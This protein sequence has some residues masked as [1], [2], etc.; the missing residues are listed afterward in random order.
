MSSLYSKVTESSGKRRRFV[1]RENR[2]C[3]MFSVT[4]KLNA[5]VPTLVF[6]RL[7]KVNLTTSTSSWLE[8]RRSQ[9][10]PRSRHR[11]NALCRGYLPQHDT[12]PGSVGSLGDKE[13]GCVLLTLILKEPVRKRTFPP[14]RSLS[15]A[16]LQIFDVCYILMSFLLIQSKV[17]VV[18]WG[19][20]SDGQMKLSEACIEK[21]F[22]HRPLWWH[23]VA[24]NMK[25][26]WICLM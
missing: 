19:L 22:Q 14:F 17:F 1:T 24:K 5:H 11:W 12:C 25:R 4:H 26:S 16:S 21:A 2:T 8:R 15:A 7:T 3:L 23:L 20:G 6:H 13:S 18:C 10:D 9:L